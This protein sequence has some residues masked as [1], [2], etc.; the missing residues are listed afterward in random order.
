MLNFTKGN[1]S[2]VAKFESLWRVGTITIYGAEVFLTVVDLISSLDSRN[3]AKSNDNA[4]Q[5][6]FDKPIVDTMQILLAFI[7]IFMLT[8]YRKF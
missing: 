3:T 7:A 6:E 2:G 1:F 5:T 4:I 8:V